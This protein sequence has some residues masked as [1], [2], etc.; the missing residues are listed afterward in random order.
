MSMMVHIT[1]PPLSSQSMADLL[2][3][4]VLLCRGQD[5]YERDFWAYMCI[6]PSMAEAFK[7]ARDKGSFNLG[8]YGTIIEAGEGTEVPPEIKARMARDYGAKDEYEEE[9]LQTIRQLRDKQNA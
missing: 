6:K 7:N 9:L 2:C 1:P 3:T 5:M 4:I 8:D